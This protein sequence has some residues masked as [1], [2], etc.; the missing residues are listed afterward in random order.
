[1]D[2]CEKH[3]CLCDLHMYARVCRPMSVSVGMHV[4]WHTCGNQRTTLS[5]SSSYLPLCCLSA[6]TR[7]AG[8]QASCPC[9]PSHHIS[10]E[11]PHTAFPRCWDPESGG[12]ACMASTLPLNRPP[13]PSSPYFYSSDYQSLQNSCLFQGKMLIKWRPSQRRLACSKPACASHLQN[14][15]R[16]QEPRSGNGI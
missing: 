14:R 10:T 11:T 7:L 15:K 6:V 16:A 12:P 9:L 4:L 5:V 1:M 2:A 13:N 8:G 3:G